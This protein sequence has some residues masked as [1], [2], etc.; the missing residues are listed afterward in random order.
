MWAESA[1]A[2]AE[3]SEVVITALPRPEHVTAAFLSGDDGILA[4]MRP[5]SIWIEHSTTD[6]ENTNRIKELVEE[7]GGSAIEAPLT[8]GMQIQ[9]TNE[10]ALIFTHT[11][12]FTPHAQCPISLPIKTHISTSNLCSKSK[13]SQIA[14]R[15]ML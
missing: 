15:Q 8:G 2:A 7:K 10:T 13:N 4:G 6:F 5:G 12:P 9:N 1:R 14:H 3:V 11:C